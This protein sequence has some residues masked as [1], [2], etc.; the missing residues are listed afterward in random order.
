MDAKRATRISKLL[1]YGLRHAPADFGV[2]LDAEGWADVVDVLSALST[3]G[4]PV[5]AVHL[6][7]VVRESDKQRFAF[8]HDGAK[9]RASQGHSVDVDLRLV[10]IEPPAMLYHGTI[11]RFVPAIRVAG[12][13]RKSRTHVHLSADEAT[14]RVVGARRR[15]DVVLLT[16]RAAEMHHDGLAFYRSANGVWL[17]LHVPAKY[18]LGLEAEES[19]LPPPANPRRV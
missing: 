14:A 7:E 17:T 8:S 3:R 15:G 6:A 5:T 16:V 2:T 9:I 11:D 1:S 10:A 12:L 18:L 4:E 19:P 13:V